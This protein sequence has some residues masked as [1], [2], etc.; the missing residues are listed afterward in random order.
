MKRVL[1]LMV[2]LALIISLVGVVPFTASAEGEVTITSVTVNLPDSATWASGKGYVNF[3]RAGVSI[4]EATNEDMF[5]VI[6]WKVNAS[7]V[8]VG[9]AEP[10]APEI[11]Y[12]GPSIGLQTRDYVVIS[13]A[14]IDANGGKLVLELKLNTS[15]TPNTWMLYANGLTINSVHWN[16]LPVTT[17]PV[18]DITYCTDQSHGNSANGIIMDPDDNGKIDML[19]NFPSDITIT[20]AGLDNVAGAGNTTISDIYYNTDYINSPTGIFA[21][22]TNKVK[23]ATD[24]NSYKSLLGSLPNIPTN[25]DG[26]EDMRFVLPASVGAQVW[27]AVECDSNNIRAT[28]N[29]S[30]FPDS[31]GFLGLIISKENPLNEDG[32]KKAAVPGAF[33]YMAPY[34]STTTFTLYCMKLDDI[35]TLDFGAEFQGLFGTHDV[36]V[37][38]ILDGCATFP[39]AA[40]LTFINKEISMRYSYNQ[41]L[42]SI[43][44]GYISSIYSLNIDKAANETDVANLTTDKCYVSIAAVGNDTVN[45]LP[46]IFDAKILPAATILFDN[47]KITNVNGVNRITNVAIGST[48][49]DLVNGLALTTGYTAVVKDALGVVIEEADYATTDVTFET[50]VEITKT[51]AVDVSTIMSYYT[52]A[53]G[54][55]V[56]NYTHSYKVLFYGDVDGDGVIAIGDLASV[57]S[58]LLG[59]QTLSATELFAADIYKKLSVSVSN[60]IALKKQLVGIADISQG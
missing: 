13:P 43:N 60:L 47:Y 9:I 39:I 50:T 58:H 53:T 45:S 38:N 57:K 54:F 36:G 20:A 23:Y 55:D 22:N 48:V 34:G 2:C 14:S 46:T 49:E 7:K 11:G 1:A 32:T 17:V 41:Q 25:V 26:S 21:G 19:M 6:F 4:T 44:D 59:I 16:V 28:F 31:D 27:G 42:L 40:G 56:T 51:D 30:Q 5:R 35:S 3:C 15:N 10:T 52:T 18:T 12:E 29:A 8:R 33:L 37:C 24:V